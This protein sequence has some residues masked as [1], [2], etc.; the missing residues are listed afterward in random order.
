MGEWLI[1]DVARVI[2]D[3]YVDQAAGGTDMSEVSYNP[4]DKDVV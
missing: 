3:V 1:V 2:P 4:R